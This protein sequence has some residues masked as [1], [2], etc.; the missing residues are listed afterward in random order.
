MVFVDGLSPDYAVENHQYHENPLSPVPD[1][2]DK[3]PLTADSSDGCVH[4]TS[5]P[6]YSN[7]QRQE[8]LSDPQASP[9]HV[10]PSMRGIMTPRSLHGETWRS[11]SQ[12]IA[13][14]QDAPPL[15]QYGPSAMDIELPSLHPH[16][17]GMTESLISDVGGKPS[18]VQWRSSPPAPGFDCRRH[19]ELLRHFIDH[20]A[21]E[22]CE[23]TK[24]RIMIQS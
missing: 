2:P 12:E 11:S 21:P 23:R 4:K 1:S 8:I 14:H 10:L 3:R 16:A 22:V 19:A 17:Y 5:A 24:G 7:A 15:S 13:R 18:T 6:S 9:S 20:M